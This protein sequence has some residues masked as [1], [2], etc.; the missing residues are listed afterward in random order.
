MADALVTT[1]GNRPCITHQ[2]LVEHCT[3]ELAAWVR[4]NCIPHP[5]A[6]VWLLPVSDDA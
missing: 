6:D 3:P 1:I 4:A 5:V 2:T